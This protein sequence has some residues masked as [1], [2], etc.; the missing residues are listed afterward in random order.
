MP[1]S[2]NIM[3]ISV[4]FFINIFAIYSVVKSGKF[5]EN[6]NINAELIYINHVINNLR[7]DI[8]I[9]NEN[10]RSIKDEYDT[11]PDIM[12]KY[13]NEGL[14]DSQIAKIT[15]KSVREVELIKKINQSKNIASKNKTERKNNS[16]V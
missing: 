16:E 2:L 5:E 15:N 6:E 11:E 3:L 9:V 7:K 8:D 12:K 10:L 14:N 13:T 4:L 1:Q